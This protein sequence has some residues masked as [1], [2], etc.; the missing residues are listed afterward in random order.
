MRNSA[1]TVLHKRADKK[2]IQK[3][4][5]RRGKQRLANGLCLPPPIQFPPPPPPTDP[6]L[7]R[8]NFLCKTKSLLIVHTHTV[9]KNYGHKDSEFLYASW[10]T[11]VT[12]IA[13]GNSGVTSSDVT[14]S[15]V[16]S[17]YV[18]S[19]DVTNLPVAVLQVAT[20]QVATTLQVTIYSGILWRV[21]CC[22]SH[23]CIDSYLLA[24]IVLYQARLHIPSL[25][26]A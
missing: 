19:S 11:A 25:L 3:G 17:S 4:Y 8:H 24:D 7:L 20:L 10:P 14:S 9:R 2:K 5:R 22:P 18:T 26:P 1:R 6:S 16:T 15:G 13:I 23:N 12:E 21:F